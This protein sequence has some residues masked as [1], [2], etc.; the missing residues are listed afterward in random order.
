MDL[1]NLV[2]HVLHIVAGVVWA[3][4]AILMGFFIA[5]AVNATRPESGRF[6]QH[7]AGPGRLPIVMMIAAWVTVI[8]GIAMFAPAT[9]ALPPGIMRSPRGITLSLGALLALGAFLEGILVNA[10]SARKIGAI[11]QAI[12]ASGKGP[13]PEQAQQMQALQG[14]LSRGTARGA[15]L[16]LLAVAL[17]AAAR[18]M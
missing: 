3:G 4:G 12:A 6:M 8:C 11:G 13:T 10:P 16:L 7:L 9:G 18:W 17:M 2:L 15:V 1:V 5:P 14:K